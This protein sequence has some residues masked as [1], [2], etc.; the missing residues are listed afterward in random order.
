MIFYWYG[1]KFCQDI[2]IKNL[3]KEV[4]VIIFL[5][6]IPYWPENLVQVLV[7]DV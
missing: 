4:F 3:R 1:C 7:I 2:D 6:I 5:K